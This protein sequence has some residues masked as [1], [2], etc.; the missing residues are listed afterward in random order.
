MSKALEIL[1]SAIDELNEQLEEEDRI[2]K[3]LD[4]PIMGAEAGLD[5]LTLV[6]L[7]VAIEQ[8]VLAQTGQTVVLVDEDAMGADAHPFRNVS[9]LA[10]HIERLID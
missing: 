5:S 9:S 10:S 4:S 1:Y 6:N 7:V 2:D 8:E 3:A